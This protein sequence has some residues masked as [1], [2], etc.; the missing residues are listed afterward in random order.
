MSPARHLWR[1]VAAL[2]AALA[3][4]QA[5]A[6]NLTESSISA[7]PLGK[8]VADST[9]SVFNVNA[10]SGLVTK[11]SGTAIRL[12]SGS[13]TTP[14]IT[15][16]CA[17]SG[18]NCNRTFTVQILAGSTLSGRPTTI[19][20]FNVAN[21]SGGAGVTFSPS[22]P[23][24]AAPMTFSIVSTV[25]TFTVTFKVGLK[26]R[27]NASATTGNTDWTYTVSVS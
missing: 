27:F 3:A 7:M 20:S 15:I 5:S 8:I 10:S 24:A 23:P 19:T 26:A 21:L 14:T 17:S 12:T 22:A 9:V 6:Y 1:V 16:K 25:T 13:V 2:F 4:N 11:I 18:T